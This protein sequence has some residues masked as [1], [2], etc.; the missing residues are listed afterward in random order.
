TGVAFHHGDL[1]LDERRLVERMFR[2]GDADRA[3]LDVIICT[4]TLGMGVNLPA[5]YMLFSTTD[6]FRQGEWMFKGVRPEPLTPLEYKNFAGRAGRYRPHAPKDHHG[7]AL[8]VTD[9]EEEAAQ[10]ELLEGLIRRP[11][12]PIAPALHRWPFGLAPLALAALAWGNASYFGWA[13][14]GVQQVFAWTF[15]GSRGVKVPDPGLVPQDGS[16][17]PEDDDAHHVP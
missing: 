2:E 15:A 1:T 17:W 10:R 4:P 13:V 12:E 8:F 5:D 6:T 14:V 3:R 7:V 9:K 16:T 11:I